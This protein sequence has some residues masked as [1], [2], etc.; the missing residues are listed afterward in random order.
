MARAAHAAVAHGVGPGDTTAVDVQQAMYALAHRN[1]AVRRYEHDIVSSEQ[2]CERFRL[3]AKG[4]VSKAVEQFRAHLEWRAAY[5]LD[6][7][8]EE[9]FTGARVIGCA[10]A[11]ANAARRP[12]C[13]CSALPVAGPS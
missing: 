10:L 9:D 13:S 1:P 5:G 8:A 2:A 6:A 3:G 12:L 7:I 11:H 4:N